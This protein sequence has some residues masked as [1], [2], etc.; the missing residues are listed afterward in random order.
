M[1]IDDDALVSI[2]VSMSDAQD[3]L[4]EKTDAPLTYLHGHG[5]IFSRIEE[6]LRGKEAGAQV[7][8]QLE[9]EEAFG[10]YDPELITLVAV[11]DLGEGVA[12]GMKVDGASVGASEGV[13]TVTDIAEGMAV[14]DGNHPLA[15][16]AL[17]FEV[18]VIEVRA[19]TDEEIE[20]AD[21]VA[22]PDFV[23]VVEPISRT[24]H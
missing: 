6:E 4:L 20:A 10:D 21:A 18:T 8:V 3:N 15:G 16:S 7:R 1:K 12:V 23:R 9:P 17:R 5:D 14:L 13:H 19:A 2:D 24:L 22:L 11:D